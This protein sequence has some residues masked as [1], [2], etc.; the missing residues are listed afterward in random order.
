MDI[1]AQIQSGPANTESGG[2]GGHI[3]DMNPVGPKMG[4]Y[5]GAVRPKYPP[6]NTTKPVFFKESD[7]FGAIRP[8]RENWILHPEMYKVV[9]HVVDIKCVTGLQRVY[10]LW[11]IYTDNAVSRTTLLTKGITIRGKSVPIQTLNPNRLDTQIPNTV[12]IRVKDIPLSADDGQIER[13]LTLR[14]CVLVGK[15]NR[16]KLRIDGQL[17]NC[18]TGDRLVI[19]KGPLTEDIPR[20]IEIGRYRAKVFYPGQNTETRN[21]DNRE[22][23]KCLEPGHFIRDC[24][25]DWRCKSCNMSGHK[26]SECVKD[27]DT[28]ELALPPSEA[29]NKTDTPDDLTVANGAPAPPL[30]TAYQDSTDI[31]H[32]GSEVNSTQPVPKKKKMKSR[33]QRKSDRGRNHSRG[34]RRDSSSDNDR[35][36][37][38]RALSNRARSPPTPA[39]TLNAMT[40]RHCKDNNGTSPAASDV[41]EPPEQTADHVN[42][43]HGF[44]T[45]SG[46]FF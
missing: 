20:I 30:S 13:A 24:V 22:C 11:R 33:K 17:T 36:I 8:P 26:Q 5:A 21:T 12:R 16:E 42:M 44:A 41:G 39:E 34:V 6:L 29:P 32:S 28:E 19:V 45:D 4:S 38:R 1:P 15:V 31:D 37:N 2:I 25:N 46:E 18:D 27:F 9:G 7:L 10:G 3:G 14:G 43:R 40:K 23:R 35:E